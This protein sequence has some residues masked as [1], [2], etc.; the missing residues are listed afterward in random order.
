[1]AIECCRLDTP[2]GALRVFARDGAVCLI[3][4]GDHRD[5]VAALA[6]RFPGD[7]FVERSNPAGAASALREYFAG[8][9][10]VLDSVRA[11]PGGTPFQAAV[12]RALR[13]IPAG[14]TITYADLARRI[15]VPRAVRAV[16]AANGANPVP[17]V[18]PCHRV[19]GANGTLVGYGGGM[20]KKE[21]LLRHEGADRRLF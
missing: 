1:M 5:A 8:R 3:T 6:K 20:K 13:G 7:E 12:W 2:I 16:G 21:W 18:I 11:D 14:S 17:I 19:I 4:F 9:L 10:S 15:G